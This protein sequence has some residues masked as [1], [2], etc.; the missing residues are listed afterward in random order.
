M[1]E[2][3]LYGLRIS[4]YTGKMEGYLRYKEIPHEFIVLN[5]QR[6][7]LLKEKTGAAQMPAVELPDGRVRWRNEQ[8]LRRA[9]GAVGDPGEQR[10]SGDEGEPRRRT[11]AERRKSQRPQ[12]EAE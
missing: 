1:A 8:F 9:G 2:L 11:R 3:K 5:P 7:Q 6:I 4:Y 12:E 10:Q